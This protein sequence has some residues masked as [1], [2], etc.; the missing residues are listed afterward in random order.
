MET[1]ETARYGHFA[2]AFDFG[3]EMA[4]LAAKTVRNGNPIRYVKKAERGN[5]QKSL[6]DVTFKEET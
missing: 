1:W 6:G 3:S 5:T 4:Y 2:F